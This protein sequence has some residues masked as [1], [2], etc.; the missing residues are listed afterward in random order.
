MGKSNKRPIYTYEDWMQNHLSGKVPSGQFYE[1]SESDRLKISEM[2]EQI[3]WERVNRMKD[4]Y[5]GEY[6]KK[7]NSSL[8]LNRLK[9]GEIEALETLFYPDKVKVPILQNGEPNLIKGIKSIQGIGQINGAGL[10]RLRDE[11]QFWVIDGKRD[12]SYVKYH[13]SDFSV[14]VPV[15]VVALKLYYDWVKNTPI[16]NTQKNETKT[17]QEQNIEN[18]LTLSTI[19]DWLYE[20]KKKMSEADYNNLVSALIQYFE[21]GTFP[22]LSKPIQIKGRLNKKLFGWALNRIF[23]S[24]SKGI[25]KELLQFA[26]QNISLFTDVQ[27]DENDIRKGNLYKYFTTQTK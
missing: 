19:E 14:D 3:F 27:F 8:D 2:Q 16:N 20:F 11:Y 23:E 13:Q 5:Q 6:L 15:A 12:Y 26:K 7:E 1:I 22:T 4:K 18:D 24:Q 9:K 21:T 25:E 17:E 10:R